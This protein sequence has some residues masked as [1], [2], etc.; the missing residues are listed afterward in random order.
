MAKTFAQLFAGFTRKHGR[1]DLSGRDK[2]GKKKGG[3]AYRV[4]GYPDTDDFDKHL[5]GTGAGLGI[6]MLN[7]DGE[8]VNF[9][10]IDI[11]VYNLDLPALEKD[12]KE[13]PL[14]VVASKSGGAHLFLFCEE[15]TSAE[16]VQRRLGEWAAALGYGGCE[17]FPK[18]TQR[19]SESDMGNWINLPYFGDSRWCINKGKS[20]NLNAFLKVANAS[21]I[22]EEYLEAVVVTMGE[23]FIDGPPCLQ[24]LTDQGPPEGTRNI[25][26]ANVAVYMRW[27]YGEGWEDNLV[28]YNARKM[29]PPLGNTEVQ[30]ILKSYSRKEYFYQ[31][32][33]VPLCSFCNK[34][35]CLKREFGVGSGQVE[36]PVLLDGFVKLMSTPPVWF[37]N[38]DGQRIEVDDIDMLLS[39]RRFKKLVAETAN[40]VV[41]RMTDKRWDGV[42][43]DLLAEVEE[44]E[45]PDDASEGGQ[46]NHYFVEFIEIRGQDVER[47]RLLSGNAWID[48]EANQVYFRSPDLLEYL[49][50]QG[51]QRMTPPR[52]WAYL[53]VMKAEKT[54]FNLKGRNVQC[55]HVDASFV[56]RQDEPFETPKFEEPF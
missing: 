37:L 17:I 6:V 54:Q 53:R 27:K 33:T 48:I 11:D 13:L 36:L 18:Q 52:L 26:L 7:D 46:F 4:D 28:E 24:H 50:K 29:K 31:C 38:I 35:E 44:F 55:W 32:S 21:M 43:G 42:I 14:V 3:R 5:S 12:C 9:G 22:N 10:A 40:K 8:T 45:A 39:Q 19:L 49:K 15:P 25:V 41:P 16:L 1:F 51:M 2:D 23:D 20:V 34:R 56:T 30:A 47:D